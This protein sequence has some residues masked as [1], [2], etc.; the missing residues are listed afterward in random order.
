MLQGALKY[1]SIALI[2]CVVATGGI[3]VS[4]LTSVKERGVSTLFSPA[5]WMFWATGRDLEEELRNPTSVFDPGTPVVPAWDSE[6][7]G[8]FARYLEEEKEKRDQM[9]EEIRARWGSPE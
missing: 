3:Y 6:Q 5:H 2:T 4:N 8:N 7:I 1:A 9:M